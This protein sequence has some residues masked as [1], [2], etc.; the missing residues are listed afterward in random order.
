MPNPFE[1]NVLGGVNPGQVLNQAYQQRDVNREKARLADQRTKMQ[2]AMRGAVDGDA[3]SIESLFTLNPEMA[4]K[5]EQRLVDRKA[6]EGTLADKAKQDAE[7]AWA[8]EYRQ[9]LQSGDEASQQALIDEAE[10]NPLIEFDQTMIGKDPNQDNLVVNSMLFKGLGKEG[11]KALVEGKG[12]EKGTFSIKETPTGFVRLNSATGDVTQ[13]AN[14]S[15]AA[16]TQREKQ[17]EEL[18]KELKAQETTFQRGTTIR[19]RYDKKTGDFNKVRDA[20]GRIE[21]SATDP[22]PAGDMALIFNFMK[23][24]DPAS[25]V[26]ESEYAT[27][28]NAGSIPN[29]VKAAYNK[30]INGEGLTAEMRKDFVGRAKALMKR[31]ES[32]QKKDRAET[33]RLG[34]QWNV[35][36]DQLFGA[37]GEVQTI[38]RFQV[39]VN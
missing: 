14:D 17:K 34:K 9:A 5:M 8:I 26:R 16:K 7:Y 1:I 2:E 4:L 6:R 20:Y 27:A 32:Q 39:K 24:L 21:V 30:A 33:I 10:K 37:P 25:V 11:Y 38:G 18:T 28:Q 19:N 29:K 13:I 36:E 23:M 31:A 15:I 12:P 35:S 22:S 3:D